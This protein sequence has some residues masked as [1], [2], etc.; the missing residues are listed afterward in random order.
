[1]T[2]PPLVSIVLPASLA[3]AEVT[4]VALQACVD[5]SLQAIE[6]ILV[7]ADPIDI[8]TAG[9]PAE[10]EPRIRVVSAPAAASIGSAHRAGALAAAAPYVLLLQPTEQLHR[11]AA[12]T[13]HKVASGSDADLI[14]FDGQPAGTPHGSA[15]SSRA[16]AAGQP[17]LASDDILRHLFPAAVRGDE[18]KSQHLIR[19]SILREVYAAAAED[20]TD[21]INGRLPVVFLAC[22]A[23]D[24]Y[25]SVSDVLYTDVDRLTTDSGNTHASRMLELLVANVE[26]LTAIEPT[27]LEWARHRPNPE[28]LVDGFEAVRLRHIARA[29]DQAA[30]VPASARAGAYELLSTSVNEVDLIAA[31][32]AFSAK[33]LSALSQ[34]GT[35]VELGHKPVRHLLLTTNVLTTGGVSGVL[36]TQARM[37]LDAGYQ[38]T[39]AT[40]RAGSDEAAVP[41]GASLVQISGSARDRL[42]QWARLCEENAIDV[43]IDHRILYSRDWP[44][45][46]LAARASGAATVGWIHNFAGRPTYNGNDLHSLMKA[47]LAALAHLIVLSPLDVAFWKLR[48]IAHVSYLPNP[49]S[50]LLLESAGTVAAKGA[51]HGRRLELVWWGR[52]EEHTKKVTEL[53]AVAAALR[54]LGVEF[55]MR[56]VGPD[57]Q[58][59]TA[60]R[61]AALASAQGLDGYVDVT[62]PRHGSDLLDA[63]DS[64]D[65]F[66]NTSII[67]GY[68]LTLPEAQSRGLPIAMYELPWLSLVQDNAG[69]VSVAQGDADALAQ[70]IASLASDPARYSAMSQGSVEA[71]ARATAFNFPQLYE[72]LITGALPAHFSPAPTIADGQKV[73]NLL[74]FFAEKRSKPQAIQT[75]RRRR[76][77]RRRS[78]PRSLGERIERK[79]TGTGHRFLRIAPWGRPL[80]RRIKHALLGR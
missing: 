27:V 52:L 68:P 38:V 31:A 12:E 39:I 49:P 78:A 76:A 75:R 72:Q 16:R 10:A 59:M 63:I 32:A 29:L 80:A 71:A 8:L 22:A 7:T 42:R 35:R 4:R 44:G 19:A 9:I 5:Q 20:V 48:G 73:L 56:L 1:M 54:R 25:L 6:I 60:V 34:E 61:L 70:R 30:S 57:W 3:E 23:A 36:R 11:D 64:S 43:V 51:P 40:H 46:A 53:I 37:L 79:L 47:N 45:F 41:A 15:L 69:V 24:S 67:E 21:S 13:L 55:R 58:D 17:A 28:P 26:A 18:V 77:A 74:L 66:V 62:G 50:P 33:A 14:G 65:I 2:S